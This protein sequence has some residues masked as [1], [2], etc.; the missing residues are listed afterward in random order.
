VWGPK[1]AAAFDIQDVE[2][3][4]DGLEQGTHQIV[5]DEEGDPRLI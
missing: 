5:V 2:K 4:L 1:T 3:F